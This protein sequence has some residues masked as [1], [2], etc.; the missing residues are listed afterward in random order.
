MNIFLN[1][2]KSPEKQM[3]IELAN[4]YRSMVGM[5]AFKDLDEKMNAIMDEAIKTIDNCSVEDVNMSVLCNSRGMRQAIDKIRR[6][7]EYSI[8]GIGK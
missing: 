4:S 1:R 7:I 8:N 5:A 6:H 3:R 2:E